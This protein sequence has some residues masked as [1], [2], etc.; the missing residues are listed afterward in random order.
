VAA[1]REEHDHERDDDDGRRYPEDLDPARRP[2]VHTGR[3]A[4]WAEARLRDSGLV[5]PLTER[6]LTLLPGPRRLWIFVWA[7]VPGLNAI[8]SVLL[9]VRGSIW[10]QRTALVVVNYI[11]LSVAIVIAL[12]GSGRI[13][14]ALDELRRAEAAAPFRELNNVVGPLAL[15]VVAAAVFTVDAFVREGWTSALVRAPTWLVVGVPLWTFLWTYVWLQ[16]GLDRLGQKRLNPDLARA[17]PSLGL[18][19][20][21]GV[22]FMGLWM[23]LA[24]VVPVVLTGLPDITGVL[25]GVLVLAAGLAAFFL[26]LFRL[27]R[28]MVEVKASELAIARDLYAQAYEPV[29]AE[30]TL[31]SLERQRG[32]LTAADALEKRAREI[33]EW[34]IDEGT[35]ARVITITTS[36]IAITIGR[37][38][39]DPFG[40]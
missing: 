6:I 1:A 27:H 7:L 24:A 21:G 40:L 9:D 3:L 12:W 26:S 38:I 31:E 11:A 35:V 30:R 36:V 22:A 17:D 23:F 32:L 18:R 33:H 34:P 25:V 13:A 2:L 19:P 37:L 4:H 10:E 20:L 16:L 28:Q 8:A 5:R 14:R 15:T 39:L 29:R